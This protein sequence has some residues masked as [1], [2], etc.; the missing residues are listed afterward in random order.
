MRKSPML[1]ISSAALVLS[2][3]ILSIVFTNT[4]FFQSST[5]DTTVG[6]WWALIGILA[7]T[8]AIFS[9]LGI[10]VEIKNGS[11]CP[12]GRTRLPNGTCP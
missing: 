6:T 3:I 4:Q 8:L 7:F 11:L 2:I 5:S 9:L 12:D 10:I 1:I